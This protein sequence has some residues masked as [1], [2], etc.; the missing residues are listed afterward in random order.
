[1]RKCVLCSKD[2][3]YCPN[4]ARDRKKPTW[5]KLFDSDNCHNIFDAINDYNFNL[6]TKEETVELL[7]KCDL[8]I[9]MNNHYRCEI[10]E[11]MA[12]PKKASKPKQEEVEVVEEIQQ[13]E[14][15]EVV[16]IE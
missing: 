10:N 6:K 5:H 15:V 7:S 16:T 8:S 2:Y 1:M 4:C 12:K 11:I 14:P 9:E 3:E 13:V